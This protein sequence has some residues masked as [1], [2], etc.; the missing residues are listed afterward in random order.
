MR[1]RIFLRQPFFTQPGYIPRAAVIV[2]GALE[3]EKEAGWVVSLD[4]WSDERGNKLESGVHR[5][6]VP[7]AKIDHALYVG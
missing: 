5:V 7:F 6:F 3:A 4:T 2:E 1:V